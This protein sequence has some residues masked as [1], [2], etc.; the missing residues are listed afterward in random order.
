MAQEAEESFEGLAEFALKGLSRLDPGTHAALIEEAAALG[1]ASE[2]ADR[3]IGRICRRLGVA[4]DRGAVA[5]A[6]GRSPL[7]AF[8]GRA[9][10]RQRRSQVQPA[11][12]PALRG[13]D[14]DEPGGAE[15]RLGAVP[16]LRGVAQVGLPGLQA[17]P[18]GRRAAVR[19]RVPPG[20]AR[21]AACG[22]S[23]RLSTRFATSTWTRALE[24]L[25]RVQEFAPNL[26]GARNG[27]AKIRQRQADIARVQL[28]YQTARAGGRLVAARRRSKPGAGWSIRRRPTSRPPGPS[29]PR[30]CAGPRRWR[31]GPGTSSGPIPRPRGTSI[32]RA[33]PSPPTC[34]TPWP[35]LNRTPP[36]PPTALDAQVLGDRIRLSWTPP[37]PDGLGPLT[38]VVVR[39][40]GGPLQHPGDGTRIAEV[41]TSEFDDMHVT[42]GDTVGYAVLSK[43]GGVES[44]AA[45]SLGPF[46]FLAD[47]KDVR[48]EFR[49]SEVE[50]GWSL[51]RGVS[52]VR[53]IR[54]QGG[55]PKNPRDGDRIPAALDHALDRNLDP[56]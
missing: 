50:L 25:E 36:D 52:E 20:A 30:T 15:G 3:L 7:S 26:A 13:S 47:V 16:A 54:K 6:R 39:K 27:I 44:V 37:P 23:R 35:G 29:W 51:P 22:I 10:S 12:L 19:L 42:P 8:D 56:E 55:P 48:V 46:V 33:W 49:H 41:S 18:L 31:P 4:R 21:A 45:I 9:G 14:R 53:V 34:P 43:R 2:R 5:P 28:A 38:F 17:Q 32:A 24:H 40:R 11:A 1:I